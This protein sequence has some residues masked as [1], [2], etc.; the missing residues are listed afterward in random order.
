[1]HKKGI[2]E[3]LGRKV[4]YRAL[5]WRRD[6]NREKRVVGD[7]IRRGGEKK[8]VKLKVLKLKVHVAAAYWV[9][10]SLQCSHRK[11]CMLTEDT[12]A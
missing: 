8:H 1:M 2:R 6:Y 9:G 4:W 3:E 5:M 7:K 12:L 10:F 11:T